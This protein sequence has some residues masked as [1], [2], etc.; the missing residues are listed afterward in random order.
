MSNLGEKQGFDGGARKIARAYYSEP[1][2]ECYYLP[3]NT[4]TKSLGERIRKRFTA[5]E[6]K[7]DDEKEKSTNPVRRVRCEIFENLSINGDYAGNDR[8]KRNIRISGKSISEYLSA[9]QLA[10]IEYANA[11]TTFYFIVE[12]SRINSDQITLEE[13]KSLV[14]I[15]CANRGSYDRIPVTYHSHLQVGCIILAGI[16]PNRLPKAH[17]GVVS[18]THRD[19]EMLLP[20]LMAFRQYVQDQDPNLTITS[21][22]ELMPPIVNSLDLY[23]ISSSSARTEDNIAY[24]NIASKQMTGQL[25]EML[26]KLGII[27]ADSVARE[28]NNL[29]SYLQQVRWRP[30]IQRKLNSLTEARLRESLRTVLRRFQIMDAPSSYVSV[31][32]YKRV[33]YGHIAL[34]PGLFG[35][36][37]IDDEGYTISLHS[38]EV[39]EDIGLALEQFTEGIP[40]AAIL[41]SE[42]NNWDDTH[43]NYYLII[44]P[45]H[46]DIVSQAR[47][48]N[49]RLV[50]LFEYD[51]VL[52]PNLDTLQ[53]KPNYLL[54]SSESPKLPLTVTIRKSCGFALGSQQYVTQGQTE[55]SKAEGKR[56]IAAFIESRTNLHNP[57]NGDSDFNLIN[58]GVS[59]QGIE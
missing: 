14:D 6:K 18:G 27:P 28:Y 11:D 9:N 26:A 52:H 41:F 21:P 36:Q 30:E 13:L 33:E 31:D 51:V 20:V 49:N 58:F 29:L 2:E 8:E 45:N 7:V 5:Q 47:T 22:A 35:M 54:D 16:N 39:D 17:H 57:E 48:H 12:E 10:V 56:L 43:T 4:Q 46:P 32:N 3:R 59:E 50:P 44:G 38:R 15:Q 24:I 37:S 34:T 1:M 55:A 25:K 42:P 53:Q 40:R 19:T 23:A